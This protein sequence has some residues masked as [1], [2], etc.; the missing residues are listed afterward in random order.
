MKI[1]VPNKL[2]LFKGQPE[3]VRHLM[4]GKNK[5]LLDD[6][7]FGKTAQAIVAANSL[8]LKKILIICPPNVRFQW[9]RECKKWS[10]KSYDH[11]VTVG[12]MHRYR[13]SERTITICPYNLLLSP[14]IFDQLKNKKWGA[15]ISDEL[16]NCSNLKARR[17]QAVLGR[18]GLWKNSVFKWGL[19]GTPMTKSP[20]DLWP[21]V[22][23]LGRNYFEM[24]WMKYTKKF[25]GRFRAYKGWDVGGTTNPNK[26]NHMLFKSGFALRRERKQLPGSML[27]FKY[28][29][30][31]PQKWSSIIDRLDM[32][33]DNLGLSAAELAGLRSEAGEAK[34]DLAID[35]ILDRCQSSHKLVVFTW[36]RPVTERIVEKLS[37]YFWKVEKYYGGMTPRA[38]QKSLNN[39]IHGDSD[40]LVAN[41]VSAGSALDGLQRVCSHCIFAEVPW[42]FTDIMQAFKRLERE[43][44]TEPVIGDILL[45]SDSIEDHAVTGL[46]K[47]ENVFNQVF[48]PSN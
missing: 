5:L 10:V 34:A 21:A 39:F 27:R 15:L 37:P 24:D 33:Q 40:V 23:T 47:K 22:S 3:G 41:I 36:H 14:M 44:Q 11:Q 16:Q 7:G 29:G 8:G 32:E 20:I 4:S 31:E 35:Y 30:E 28:I 18:K 43:G 2:S 1:R 19:S 26:L 46:V 12:K 42:N 17:T 45:I 25:C 38:Q 9:E 13:H 48:A 6:M